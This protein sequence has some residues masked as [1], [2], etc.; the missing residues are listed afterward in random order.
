LSGRVTPTGLRAKRPAG[1]ANPTSREPIIRSEAT[2]KGCFMLREGPTV[3]TQTDYAHANWQ[4]ANELRQELR[5]LVE[6]AQGRDLTASEQS[7][8][9]ELRSELE[10]ANAAVG[11]LLD[12]AART[13]DID[14]GN[15]ATAHLLGGG[16]SRGERA[17]GN[18][19][20]VA[21]GEPQLREAHAGV[22][23]RRATS[24]TAVESRAVT[25]A[26]MSVV[27]DYRYEPVAFAREP[28]RVASYMPTQPT[29]AA[30][31]T[32]YRGTTAA[33]AA[34]TVAEGAAKPE[35]TPGWT[36][37]TLPVRKLAHFVAV[38]NEALADFANFAAVVEAEMVAGLILAENAQVLSGDGTGTN[39]V[40]LL[41][42]SG[43]QTYAPGAAEQRLLSILHGITLLRSGTSFLEADRIFVNPADWEIVLKTPTTTGELI[44]SATPALGQPL[45]LWGVPVTVTSQVAAGTGIVANLA[46]STV[47]FSREP[48]KLFVDPYSASTSNLIKVIAEERLALGVTRPTGICRITYNGAA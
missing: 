27:S 5:G 28:T 1:R 41:A 7:R 44:V 31:V 23:E 4:R 34:A 46:A 17:I 37:V 12:G 36:P 9:T 25:A 35:S 38:S 11:N 18:L 29:E 39:L 13:A 14:A 40:G 26:P 24:V 30:S 45:S 6:G 22:L 19:P 42:T 8:C 48:A 15:V 10:A 16:T 32:F 3:P 20:P 43:I 21:F 33:S 2:P 47:V